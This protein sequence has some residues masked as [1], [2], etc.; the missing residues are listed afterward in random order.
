MFSR[1]RTRQQIPVQERQESALRFVAEQDGE[2]ERALKAKWVSIL[3]EHGGVTRAFLA[4]ATS[5]VVPEPSVTLCICPQSAQAEAL[6]QALA[7]PLHETLGS[8]QHL[9]IVFLN[10]TLE[11]EV[12]RVA[13]PFFPQPNT[14]L[15]RTREG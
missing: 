14:S 7:R 6:V 15:E 12:S 4:R 11:A 10:A 8:D 2:V 13:R 5:A 9:D 1:F 3:A